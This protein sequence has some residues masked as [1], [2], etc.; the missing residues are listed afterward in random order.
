MTG[1]F[2]KASATHKYATAGGKLIG[3]TVTDPNGDA[4]TTKPTSITVFGRLAGDFSYPSVLN[5]GD[6]ALFTTTVTN[7]TKTLKGTYNFT[8]NWD[9]KDGGTNLT[10][11]S[12]TTLPATSSTYHIIRASGLVPVTVTVTDTY[13]D[14]TV[15]SLTHGIPVGGLLGIDCGYGSNEAIQNATG[16]PGPDGTL[17]SGNAGIPTLDSGCTWAGGPDLTGVLMPLVSDNPTG[18]LGPSCCLFKGGGFTAEIV[19]VQG[20]ASK[21]NGFD[22]TLSWNPKIL[23]AVEFDQ[24]GLFWSGGNSFTGSST[25]DNTAGMAVLSQAILSPPAPQGSIS[26]NVTL[27]R[28]RFDVVGI[29]ATSLIISNGVVEDATSSFVPPP[30]PHATIQG[31]FISSNIPDA[32][33]GVPL[34]Y[35]VS[36]T[37]SPNPEVPGS[38]L[39]LVAT[40]SCTSCTL[41][42]SYR[43]DTDSVQGY[44]A[45]GFTQTIEA[46]GQSVT[47][48]APTATL[49]AHRVTLIV[50]DTLGHVAEA[51]RRLPLAGPVV[52]P[53]ATLSVGTPGSFTARWLGGI[54]PYSGT[55]GQVGVKWILCN[56]NTGPTQLICSNPTTATTTTAAQVNTI[57]NT[58]KFAGVFTGTVIVTDTSGSDSWLPTT[59]PTTATFQVNVTGTPKAFTVTLTTDTAFSGTITGTTAKLTATITYNSGYPTLARSNLF[60][61]TFFFGDGTFST[62]QA[63]GLTGSKTHTFGS[64]PTSPAIVVIQELSSNSLAKVKETG[65]LIPTGNFSFSP[66]SLTSGQ[67]VSFSATGTGGQPPYTYSWDFG[68]GA[69]ATGPS[70]THTYST[71]G[72]Y[73]VTLTLTDYWGYT[74][75]S[76]QTMVVASPSTTSAASTFYTEVG[77]GI[78]AAVVAATVGLLIVRRRRKGS[79]AAIGSITTPPTKP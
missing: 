61:Y 42:L 18:T 8:F 23:Y 13:G 63:N 76:T 51:T 49:L 19:Y 1:N 60:N 22:V 44:P 74:F 21:I 46:T 72:N 5:F 36:W 29:G 43:W 50:N 38:A 17:S 48:A 79:V 16:Y 68:D 58:Y 27:F 12:V 54:P 31:S 73:T 70:P 67:T 2:G 25:I 6:H 35:S 9:Y 41:P 65:F 30:L 53:P 66:G 37:L 11:V 26:G 33:A 57:Q 64:V 75:A 56:S 32:I 62:F 59:P 24:G 40:A 69:K 77:A 3:L 71:S 52:V 47:I 78:V 39:S 28:I 10:K 14:S 45:P 55:T 15:P 20:G 4:G 34:G 7:G